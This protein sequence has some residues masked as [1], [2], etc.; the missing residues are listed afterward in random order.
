MVY[1]LLPASLIVLKGI[2]KEIAETCRIT[3]CL[4]TFHADDKYSNS[5]L[6]WQ[7]RVS[8]AQFVA[9]SG[10]VMVDPM[11]SCS[12]CET[13]LTINHGDQAYQKSLKRLMT[14]TCTD[15]SWP[16]NYESVCRNAQISKASYNLFTPERCGGW[17]K[18]NAT[19]NVNRCVIYHIT[20]Y[21]Y[22]FYN[23]AE[24]LLGKTTDSIIMHAEEKSA[25]NWLLVMTLKRCWLTLKTQS[26]NQNKSDINTTA[27]VKSAYFYAQGLITSHTCRKELRDTMFMKSTGSKRFDH[28][29]SID[30]SS[31]VCMHYANSSWV[32]VASS[33]LDHAHVLLCQLHEQTP[34]PG[35]IP[36]KNTTRFACTEMSSFSWVVTERLY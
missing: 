21:L 8:P 6:K 16:W 34:T 13:H 35:I 31:N 33:H 26:N 32:M 20:L 2:I 25:A 1:S 11:H 23:C 15:S 30:I 9:L 27:T 14:N 19:L 24:Q 4:V 7:G 22:I 10:R 18:N 17:S 5:N 3:G 36:G 28:L 12:L 29:R